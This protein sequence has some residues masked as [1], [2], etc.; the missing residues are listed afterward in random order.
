[1]N[2]TTT[3]AL[4]GKEPHPE[5]ILPER[6]QTARKYRA[7]TKTALADR[8][9]VSA[10]AVTTYDTLGAPFA[11]AHRLAEALRFPPEFFTAADIANDL[12]IP[13]EEIID[14]TFN[15]EPRTL[16]HTENPKIHI[17]IPPTKAPPRL[18]TT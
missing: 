2:T 11:L 4:S 6:T 1:M 8:L 9:G 10:R 16:N 18:R 14:L 13:R 5:T 15:I 7:I 17:P 12:H 3:Q